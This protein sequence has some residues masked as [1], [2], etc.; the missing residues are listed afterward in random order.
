VVEIKAH[1]HMS[2]GEQNRNVHR[3][4]QHLPQLIES[5]ISA[6][7]SAGQAVALVTHIADHFQFTLDQIGNFLQGACF[8]ASNTARSDNNSLI[9]ETDVTLGVLSCEV[10]ICTSLSCSAAGRKQL[11]QSALVSELD[12]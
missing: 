8:I 7:A 10:C 6:G 1:K 4:N 5:L 12:I 3:N 11:D 9:G 2:F